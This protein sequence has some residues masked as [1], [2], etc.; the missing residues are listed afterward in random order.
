MSQVSDCYRCQGRGQIVK[1]PCARCH[2]RGRERQ[3]RK[4][5]VEI[6]AG[7]DERSRIRRTGEGEA[8]PYGGPPGDLYI[9]VQVKPHSHFQR[10]GRDLISEIEISF[11]RAALGGLAEVRTLEGAES[12]SIPP[13]TQPG[14][15]FSIRGKGLPE[16]G[17][18]G[19]GDQHVVV[20]VRTP[21]SLNERQRKALEEFAEASGE[22]LSDAGQPPH[23]D[24]GFF[25]W[26]RNLF[27]GKEDEAAETRE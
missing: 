4:L 7:V 15:V 27:S 13:G 21:S 6:P 25:G 8:G 1:E 24:G 19:R 18:A 16:Y 10:R 23:R 14:E 22:D 20:R 17:R 12:H 9:F 26:V 11:A 3:T 2:G 5:T